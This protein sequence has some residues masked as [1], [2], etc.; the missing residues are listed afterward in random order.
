M[1]SVPLKHLYQVLEDGQGLVE[2]RGETRAGVG[3]DC[4]PVQPVAKPAGRGSRQGGGGAAARFRVS[5]PSGRIPESHKPW[6]H[7]QLGLELR[8]EHCDLLADGGR[9]QGRVVIGRVHGQP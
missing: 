9:S 3:P 4:G 6:K 1:R 5:P 7:T 2:G 8:F